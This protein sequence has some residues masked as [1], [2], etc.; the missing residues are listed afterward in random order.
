MEEYV[1]KQLHAGSN[2]SATSGRYQQPNQHQFQQ[3]TNNVYPQQQQQN[4]YAPPPA[5]SYQPPY[6]TQPI[7]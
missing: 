3:H 6:Q 5:P 4:Y 7:R 2:T 1:N